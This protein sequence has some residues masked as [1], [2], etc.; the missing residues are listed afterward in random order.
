[1]HVPKQEKA[2]RCDEHLI[3]SIGQIFLLQ[4]SG[5]LHRF[6]IY[7]EALWVLGLN[8]HLRLGTIIHLIRF[9]FDAVVTINFNQV[10][11]S[12]HEYTSPDN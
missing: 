2:H 1:M 7:H 3:L 6:A 9:N 8:R 11:M 10:V 12:P 4:L 5:Q